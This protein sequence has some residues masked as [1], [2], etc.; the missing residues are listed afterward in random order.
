MQRTASSRGDI[1]ALVA[2]VLGAVLVVL[3]AA[4]YKAFDLDRF[5]IPKELVLHATAMLA[6][7]A[8][9]VGRRRLELGWVDVALV[10]F[11]LLGLLSS[12]LATN[13]W[14]AARAVAISLSGVALYWVARALRH[15]GHG[16]AVAVGIVVAAAVGAATSLAQAYGIESQYFSINRA[17]G[18][19]FGNRNF[20]AHA[21]A[22][23][24][25]VTL[26]FALVARRSVTFF[27]AMLCLLALAATLVLSRSRAAWVALAAAM[28]LV[29]LAGLAVRSRWR[30]PR[31]GRRIVVLAIG[32]TASIGAAVTLPNTLNWRSDNPYLESVRGVVNYREGSGR[33]RIVQYRNSVRMAL[34]HPLL[35]V[36]P[37]NWAVAY[38]RYAS[39]NDPSLD[40]EDMTANPWP[41]S[42]WV[43]YLS[44]RGIA[45]T[46]L[47]V[48]V[49]VGIGIGALRQ[50]AAARTPEQ[51]AAALALGGTLVAAIGVGVFDAV[52]MLAAP[53]L[54]VWPLLGALGEP[55]AT[56]GHVVLERGVHQ[57]GPAIVFALGALAVMHSAAQTAAMAVYSSDPERVAIV[58]RASLLDPG[59]YRMHVRL[60][61][62][63]LSR[64]SCTNAVSHA[65]AARGLFP[66]S[67][68]PREILGACGVRVRSR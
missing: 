31:L 53:T 7:L 59:S 17:P 55:R 15:T 35:G 3:V 62:N 58:R 33:G 56:Q 48:L 63:Y 21:A 47:L 36:G 22:I 12:V 19:T 52:L 24:F 10:L 49:F 8:C 68:R 46:A 1:A 29:L 42:D 64:G 14:V 38:P 23:A 50:L 43:A 41:S 66:N 37:G 39:R 67:P 16:R 25:P 61:E 27:G 44:E 34:A 40:S 13:H 57:W 65:R 11:L 60:A 5:F 20:V 9:L 28:A 26:L 2:L 4:P 32:I 51:I 30:D 54:L 6:A 45:A 18:G